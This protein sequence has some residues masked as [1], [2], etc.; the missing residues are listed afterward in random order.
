MMSI[1]PETTFEDVLN[2]LLESGV[3][4]SYDSLL[5]AI[6]DYPQFSA[7]LAE[8]FA[9]WA[10]QMDDVSLVENA[11]DESRVVSLGLSHAL[12]L[13]HEQRGDAERNQEVDPNVRLTSL[14]KAA[15]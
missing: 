11:S 2:T 3:E 6:G 12:N 8:F 13:L 9:A 1:N 10:E 14:A 4:P 5:V 15:G 7:E